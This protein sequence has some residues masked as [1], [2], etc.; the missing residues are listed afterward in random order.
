MPSTTGSG[1]KVSIWARASSRVCSTKRTDSPRA[2]PIATVMRDLLD[3]VEQ[4]FRAM[5]RADARGSAVAL[6]ASYQGVSPLTNT[7]RDPDLMTSEVHHLEHW[8]DSLTEDPTTG[9]DDDDAD[10]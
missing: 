5:G 7:F 6:I 9:G 1:M 10:E 3:W 2:A 4:Q 8:F